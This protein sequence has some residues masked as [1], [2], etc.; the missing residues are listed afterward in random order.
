[1]LSRC[2]TIGLSPRLSLCCKRRL[3]SNCAGEPSQLVDASCLHRFKYAE[4]HLGFV[5]HLCYFCLVFVMLSCAS[6]N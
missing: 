3:C 2:L 1:M 5:D 6:V 4:D